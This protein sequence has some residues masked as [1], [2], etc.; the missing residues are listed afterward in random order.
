MSRA[1]Q[2]P[3]APRFQAKEML[4]SRRILQSKIYALLLLTVALL[5]TPLL[6]H[7]GV[8]TQHLNN[9]AAGPYRVYVWSDP[10]PPEVGEYHVTIALTENIEGDT[11]GLAGGPVLDANV[12]VELTHL[13]SGEIFS[14]RATH[15][16]ALN[17]LFYEAS[18]APPRQG[19][20][21]VQVRIAAPG[22]GAEEGG[23]DNVSGSSSSTCQ[24]EQVVS[25]EDEILPNVFPWRA[26]LGGL[27]ALVLMIGAGV[28]YWKTQPPAAPEEAAP[29]REGDSILEGGRS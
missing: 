15:D 23:G 25:F 6:A 24:P 1:G 13:E 5:P 10:E 20:W 18:F 27:L 19:I 11:T 12:V 16:D 9:E 17:K 29:T 28:L 7:A 21:S 14:A 2:A 22:C 4:K 8:G 26:L 3:R